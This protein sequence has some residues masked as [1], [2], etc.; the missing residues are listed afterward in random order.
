MSENHFRSHFWPFQINMRLFIFFYKMAPGCHFGCPK[1]T[2]DRISSHFRAILNFFLD[3]FFYKMTAG[4]QFG[5]PKKLTF[6]RKSGH[7]RFFPAAILYVRN[8][9]SM[10]FLA[11]WILINF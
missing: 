2:F 6:D 8:S 7:F 11:I 10:A 1:I 4:A 9:L 3:F 5:C